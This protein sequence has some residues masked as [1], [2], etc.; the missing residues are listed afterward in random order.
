MEENDCRKCFMIN[1]HKSMGPGLD[2][3][4]A[5]GSA[6]RHA[7]VARHVTDLAMRP[8]TLATEM[9]HVYY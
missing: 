3:T 2:R 6:V 1:L 8:S 9:L 5:P 7:S 4:H